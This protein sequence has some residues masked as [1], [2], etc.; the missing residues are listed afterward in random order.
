MYCFQTNIQI[1][2]SFLIILIH[3][4]YDEIYFFKVDFNHHKVFAWKIQIHLLNQFKF[5]FELD[6]RVLAIMSL[7]LNHFLEM[8]DM[9]A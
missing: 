9:S 1:S 6:L 7:C 5:S 4:F 2:S 8:E 3:A